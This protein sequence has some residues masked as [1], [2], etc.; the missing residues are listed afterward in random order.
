MLA[1]DPTSNVANAI[2]GTFQPGLDDLFALHGQMAPTVNPWE[3]DWWV[4]NQPT[5]SIAQMVS[6]P[7]VQTQGQR[8][9][10]AGGSNTLGNRI[11]SSAQKQVGVPYVWGGESPSGFDCSGLVY[12]AL[13]HAG[14]KVPRTTAQGYMQM[15]KPV[16][17][18]HLQPGDLIFFNFAG[19]KGAE[20]MG[21]YAGGGTAG[22]R[23]IDAPHTGANVRIDTIPWADVVGMGRIG[24]TGAIVGKPQPGSAKPTPVKKLGNNAILAGGELMGAQGQPDF[25]QVLSSILSP[26]THPAAHQTQGAGGTGNFTGPNAATEEQLYKGFVAAGRQDLARMVGTPA[27]DTWIQAESGWRVHA[28]SSADNQGQANGGL[29][30]FW[31]GHGFTNPYQH[32]GSFSASAYQQAIMVA[33]YFH[34]TPAD[35]QRY[36]QQIRGGS[37][38]GWG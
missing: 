14:I 8:S 10:L 6:T 4:G 1:L 33:K 15:A 2:T 16:N 36:A 24:R 18:D 5:S 35:I 17:S 34:L 3:G 27:F 13:N 31:Y 26:D 38:Q 9:D 7:A 20:H 21:I 12:W 28:Q 23:Y 19:G 11:I 30:Q 25:G 29:F 32:N 22:G 37:Y